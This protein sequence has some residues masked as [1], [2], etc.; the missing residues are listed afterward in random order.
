M[1]YLCIGRR[2]LGKTTL[3]YRMCR[4]IGKRFI[5]DARR[6]IIQSGAHVETATDAAS[7]ED[8]MYAVVE[9]SGIEESIYQPR[10]APRVAFMEWTRVLRNLV[11]DYPRAEIAVLVDEASFYDLDDDAFQWIV[12]CAPRSKVHVIIT[13]HQPKDIPTSIRSIADHWFVFYTTQQTDL[14]R[15][16]EKS[17]D[18]ARLVRS[19]QGRDYVHWDDA[20]AR[21]TVNRYSS[22]WFI[23]LEG[24]ATDVRDHS[25]RSAPATAV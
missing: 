10:E 8:S 4:N 7:A 3:A 24:V 13:A 6:M 20:K 12:K 16:D 1:I 19:L 23:A 2:E 11:I 5:L 9:N 18:A 14:D 15:I 22:N 25:A 17:P 21:L